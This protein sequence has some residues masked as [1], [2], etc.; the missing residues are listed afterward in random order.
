[1]GLTSIILKNFIVIDCYRSL[2]S[3]KKIFW[4]ND[5]Q[6]W[7]R[8]GLNGE[9]LYF[10]FNRCINPFLWVTTV[11]SICLYSFS[12]FL[13]CP[14]DHNST[15]FNFYCT[16]A[17]FDW[18]E[19]HLSTYI[20]IVHNWSKRFLFNVFLYHCRCHISCHNSGIRAGRN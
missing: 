7:A 15:S 19:C 10:L 6:Y 16:K 11:L 14:K 4:R 20:N 2:R 5:V 13:K 9:F 12:L 17:Q 1:M 18:N 3:I 8:H